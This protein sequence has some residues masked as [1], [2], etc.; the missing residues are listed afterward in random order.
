MESEIVRFTITILPESSGTVTQLSRHGLRNTNV[1]EHTPGV[2]NCVIVW[3]RQRTPLAEVEEFFKTMR[4]RHMTVTELCIVKK[5]HS[6]LLK[7]GPVATLS[8]MPGV[9]NR[10]PSFLPENKHITLW[11]VEKV[12]ENCWKE[13]WGFAGVELNTTSP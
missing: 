11:P 7:S 5:D 2:R 8:L 12:M 9:D 10:F 13:G 4:F 6:I 1:L 3:I